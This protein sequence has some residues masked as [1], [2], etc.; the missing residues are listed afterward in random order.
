MSGRW[1]R[2]PLFVFVAAGLGAAWL[3]LAP[4]L[5]ARAQPRGDFDHLRSG[6]PLTGAHE[7]VPCESCHLRGVFEGTPTNCGTCHTNGAPWQAGG[8]SLHHVRSSD[9]CGDCHVTNSW[10][11]ARF[12]HMGV[13]SPC[14]SCHNGASAEGKPPNH[15]PSSDD[16]ESC[17]RTLAWVP[18]TFDHSA[19]T[20]NCFSCHNGSTATGKPQNHVPSSNTCETCHNTMS[21]D[22]AGGFDHTGITGNCFSCHNGTTATGKG[23]NHVQSPNTCE[24]CHNTLSWMTTGAFDHTGIVGNCGSCHNGSTATGKSPNHF[25]TNLDCAECH[26]P[27]GWLPARYR[28]TG[29][30]YPGDHAGNPECRACHTSNAQTVPYRF[31]AYA[32]DCAGCHANDFDAGEHDQS[33]S[34]LRDCA[35]ACHGSSG[36]H[37]VNRGDW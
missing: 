34:E 2:L 18:A 37:R 6:F 28:H 16:C 35:G 15:V 9:Q 22:V 31:A 26:T 36:R 24:S 20:G 32:P 7:R 12:D 25:V 29:P 27:A 10:K 1:S 3:V 11:P 14:I 21:W 19:I 23:P 8:K 13:T 30:N 17:H 5:P 4:A 33:L